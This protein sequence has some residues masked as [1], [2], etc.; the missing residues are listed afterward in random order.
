ME[1]EE[2]EILFDGRYSEEEK[3]DIAE[4]LRTQ[5]EVDVSERI[6]IRKAIGVPLLIVITIGVPLVRFFLKGFLE[7]KGKLLAQR[8]FSPAQRHKDIDSLEIIIKSKKEE[9][10]LTITAKDYQ[11]LHLKIKN[12]SEQTEK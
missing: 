2:I 5:F 4:T 3:Q 12:L 1:K 11:E 7:E 9:K 6:I 8:F 10:E